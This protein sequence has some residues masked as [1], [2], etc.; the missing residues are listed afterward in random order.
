MGEH[1]SD[2]SWI[3]ILLCL[4]SLLTTVTWYWLDNDLEFYKPPRPKRGH[5]KLSDVCKGCREVIDKVKEGYSQTWKKQEENSLK[6]RSRLRKQCNGFDMAIITQ[7]NTPIGS[8]LVYD[9]DGKKTLQVTREIFKTFAKEHPFETKRLDTCA[10]VGNGGILTDSRCGKSIDSAQFVMRCNLPP[11]KNGYEEYVG[12]KTDL[13]TANPS[14]L[15]Q[16]YGSLMNRRRPFVESLQIYGNALLVLPAFSYSFNTAVSL[17]AAYTIEDSDSPVRP[18]FFNPGYLRNLFVF[19][20]NEG[21]KAG[22]LSTGFI[23]TSIA[24]EICNNVELYG[25]WPFSNHPYDYYPLS[26]HYY[27]DMKVSFVHAMPAEFNILLQLHSE[28][29][30]KL[31]LGNC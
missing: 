25:F 23:M 12:I 19:W 21:L 18:V 22:R 24:L 29:V 16:K 8:E 26:N 4:G 17:R 28:G 3:V 7:E 15:M 13:V 6:F 5:G 31:H 27:D 9:A 20:R 14:I 11:L 10:L 30:L 2:V 1:N